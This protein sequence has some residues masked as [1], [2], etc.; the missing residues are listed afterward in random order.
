M[1]TQSPLGAI[2]RYHNI[3][4]N[5]Y[6]DDTQL[7]CSF[8]I[9][10][11]DKVLNL[12]SACISDVRSWMIRNKLKITDD[13]TEFLS[14]TSPCTK[15]TDVIYISIGQENISTSKSCKSLGVMF[16]H[17]M[18]MNVQIKNICRSAQFHIQNVSAIRH[19]LPSVAAQIMHSLI[20]S[21]LDYCNSILYVLPDCKI[22]W[23]KRVQNIAAM[24]VSR[25]SKYD[26]N[27][28]PYLEVPTL[29]TGQNAN[30]L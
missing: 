9:K 22:N 5:I 16:D 8:D 6:A 21:R 24:V 15:H 20:T 4:Y 19:L 23:L 29:V 3:D 13:K 14:I 26:H 25:F 7:Y 11:L 18:S 17:H 28:Y 30:P 12:M 27:Y 10:S 1:Y 2:L